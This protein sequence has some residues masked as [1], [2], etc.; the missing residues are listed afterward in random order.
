VN[1]ELEVDACLTHNFDLIGFLLLLL[2]LLVYVVYICSLFALLV[3]AFFH[4]PILSNER[5]RHEGRSIPH[6]KTFVS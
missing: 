3:I 5:R 1:N 6:V 2:V 4:H